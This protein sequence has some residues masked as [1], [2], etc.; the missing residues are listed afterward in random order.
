[1]SKI[2]IEPLLQEDNNRFVMF[3]VSDQTI[4]KMYK[5]QVDCFWRPEEIDT[6][7]D[8]AHW[9]KLSQDEQYFI[10]LILAFFAASDGI[11]LENLALRFMS[12]VQLPEARAFYGFQ[13][14]MENI[15]SETYSILIDSYIKNTEEKTSL[16]QAINNF[17]CI[18]KKA[19]W[20]LK[21]I[22]DKRSSFATRLIAFACIEGIFFSGAFCSIY[23]LKKRGLMPG[24]T[25]SN[26]LISRDEA[27]HTEFAVYLYSKL[28]KKIHKKKIQEIIQD[29]VSIEQEF[30]TEALPC[31]LIGMNSDL[32][33]KYIEFVADRLSI[34][35]G[36]EPIYNSPNPF[37]FMEMISLEQKTNFFE[38]RVSEYSLAEKSG[39]DEAFDEAF[40]F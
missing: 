15:H 40:E 24:L 12:E 4:W 28:E 3:P 32:M 30:I 31:R 5:K 39:K 37:D 13:I 14:A 17:P 22:N 19:K 34:Q 6:S 27:L 38:S 20:A 35:F 23:W 7:K 16:F 29:A 1:M 10:K 26:E 8:L 9:D 2:V 33:N 25:F 18:E 36:C 11:V 21:W